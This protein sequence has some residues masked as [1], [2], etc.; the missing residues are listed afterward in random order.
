MDLKLDLNNMNLLLPYGILAVGL[1]VR[2]LV[3][4]FRRLR[5]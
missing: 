2:F 1:G 4:A 5:D 3:A